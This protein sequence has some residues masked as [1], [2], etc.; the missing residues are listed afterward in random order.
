MQLLLPSWHVWGEWQTRL[1]HK[2]NRTARLSQP[3][4]N[5]D[6]AGGRQVGIIGVGWGTMPESDEHIRVAA[7]HVQ[8]ES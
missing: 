3:E 7:Q 4:G 1:T 8:A 6:G 2:Q 5:S